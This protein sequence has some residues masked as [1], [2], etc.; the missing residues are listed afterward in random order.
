MPSPDPI[1]QRTGMRLR[2]FSQRAGLTHRL[3]LGHNIALLTYELPQGFMVIDGLGILARPTGWFFYIV[4]KEKEEPD[5]KAFAD[6]EIKG[7]HY[8]AG[9]ERRH[10]K[11]ALYR[12]D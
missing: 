12:Q 6:R 5:R 11:G 9:K 3:F 7:G 1:H 2:V 8:D 10:G 4:G